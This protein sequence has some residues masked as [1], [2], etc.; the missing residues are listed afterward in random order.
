MAL[1]FELI[2][3]A[4][5][6]RLTTVP[7][8]TPE[9]VD[10]AV[11]AADRAFNK[12]EWRTMH[13]R[14][15]ART[16]F[17]L[18]TLIRDVAEELANTESRNVG[19]P[20]R[21]SRDEVG[22]AADCFE[23]YA[24]TTNKVGGQ[25]IPGNPAGVL[26]TFREPVG[27]CGI[28]VPWNFPIAITSWKVAP[29]LAMGN[30]VVLKPAEQ[31]PLTALRLAELAKEAGVPDGVFQVVTG[32]GSV[33]GD[34]LVRH[35]LVRKLAFTGSTEVGANVMRIA[36]D[37]IK[38]VSLELGGKSANIVFEDCD[39]DRAV[40]SAASSALGN[41]G[42]DCCARSRLLVQKTIYERFQKAIVDAF[43]HIKV[44]D[45]L[46]DETEMG[47]LITSAHRDRVMSYVESGKSE[48]ATLACGG[49]APRLSGSYLEPTVFL[50]ATP[51][52]KIVR[53]E[54]FGPVVTVM[55]F[56]DEEEAV[57]MAND[58]MYGLSGSIWTRD[59]SRA[60]RVA[61]AVQTGNLSINSGSSVHLEAPFG[62]VKHSGL[63]R[64]LG[65]QV[66]DHYTEWKTVYIDVSA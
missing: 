55:P 45:P 14:E 4:T 40:K 56:K 22:L 33:A 54:I 38:R 42:Q 13:P 43:N 58:S 59:I 9:D 48:G 49:Q 39:F 23:Y 63:G 12:G 60:M 51:N 61:R 34:A 47:P 5:G 57:T 21:E 2:E 36:A 24:G 62:G 50:D 32:K 20:I 66:L 35:P 18:A 6:E 8:A 65:L 64:E 28:I 41:A 53:E 46:K 17:R 52:M 29:A 31:T 3:P 16:L 26:M 7:Q 10:R 27:V 37:D 44:G 15:R 1:T 25:T 30:S 11:R 19:K